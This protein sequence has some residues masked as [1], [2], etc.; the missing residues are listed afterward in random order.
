MAT[1]EELEAQ[2]MQ[3]PE[4]DRLK[5]AASLLKSCPPPSDS[6][7]DDEDPEEVEAAWNAEIQRRA[8]EIRSGAVQGVPLEEVMKRARDKFGHPDK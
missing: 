7:Y 6:E 3:L 5:L 4:R 1:F 8:E 2:A